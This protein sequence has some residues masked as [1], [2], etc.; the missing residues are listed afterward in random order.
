MNFHLRI[1]R[2]NRIDPSFFARKHIST[3]FVLNDFTPLRQFYILKYDIR[4]SKTT[5]RPKHRQMGF[6]SRHKISTLNIKILVGK[7]VKWDTSNEK[8]KRE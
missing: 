2:I 6:P 8:G 5:N 3:F 1:Y 7:T 4:F